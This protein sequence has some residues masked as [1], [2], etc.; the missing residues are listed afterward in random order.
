MMGYSAERLVLQIRKLAS[1][2][3]Y[4]PT[5]PITRHTLS[6]RGWLS[7]G[8]LPRRQDMTRMRLL[9]KAVPV[10]NVSAESVLTADVL[11]KDL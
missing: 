11:T 6:Q 10:M 5:S 1:L 9:A 8:I 2:K 7:P 4:R 3:V